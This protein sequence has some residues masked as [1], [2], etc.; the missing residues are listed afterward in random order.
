MSL[1]SYLSR[2][3]ATPQPTPPES[4]ALSQLAPSILN[5]SISDTPEQWLLYESLLLAALRTGDDES[6]RLALQ[7]L[8]DRFGKDNNRIMALQG[9]YDEAVANSTA[10]LEDVLKVY[11]GILKDEPANMVHEDPPLFQI[12]LTPST[13]SPSR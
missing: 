10:E 4:L 11:E 7:R 1:S 12:L 8:T 6:A 5:S 2:F 9:L 3:V 13:Y